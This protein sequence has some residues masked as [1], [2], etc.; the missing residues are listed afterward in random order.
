MTICYKYKKI[1]V[2]FLQENTLSNI[3]NHST[4]A[5]GFAYLLAGF[6]LA[7]SPGLKRFVVIPLLI[8]I[9]VFSGLVWLGY[10]QFDQLMDQ[11]IPEDSWWSVLRWLLWPLFAMAIILIVFYTF[12]IIA[13]LIASP[14]NSLLAEKT[15]LKLRGKP[16]D[17]GGNMM[18]M[19]K[20]IG[21]SI[22]SEVRK[23][24][25]FLLR[26]I[27]LLILF[28]IPGINIIA[29]V[30]WF[31]F[32][33]WFIAIEYT[34]FPMGNH[35]ILFKQQLPRLRQSRMSSLGFGTAMTLMMMIPFVNFF[36]MP[37]GVCGA[38]KFWVDE[39]SKDSH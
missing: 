2:L 5:G 20:G 34:D 26:A 4:P 11:F 35:D 12:T 18:D 8:N 16:I 6:K 25:Y 37:A 17:Q 15:E 29:A 28:L 23:M 14:F 30:L 24:S 36:A 19:L 21:P 22:W 3:T 38:T 10:T 39:L 13:N 27:P 1:A 31:V 9:L 33:A 32:G 7:L